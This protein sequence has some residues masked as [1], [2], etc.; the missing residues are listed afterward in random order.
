MK[1]AHRLHLFQLREFR[2]NIYVR[3]SII[4]FFTLPMPF[5]ICVNFYCVRVGIKNTTYGYIKMVLFF[6]KI[7]QQT[8][9]I[10]IESVYRLFGEIES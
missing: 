8:R 4:F 3:L 10:I 1:M 7:I 5:Y 2:K 9:G 6:P